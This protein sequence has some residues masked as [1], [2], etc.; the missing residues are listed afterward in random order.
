MGRLSL[1]QTFSVMSY[2]QVYFVPFGLISR[3]ATSDLLRIVILLPAFLVQPLVAYRLS[4]LLVP[5]DAEVFYGLAH[6]VHGIAMMVW[7]GIGRF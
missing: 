7:A 5:D 3:I 1:A 6:V 2:S 4:S